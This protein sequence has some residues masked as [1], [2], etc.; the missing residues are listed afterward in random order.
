[1]LQHSANV[2]RN[3]QGVSKNMCST[4]ADVYTSYYLWAEHF[5]VDIEM[6]PTSHLILFHAGK[7]EWGTHMDHW[8]ISQRWE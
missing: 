1:M 7:Q 2:L 4:A 3:G 5:S 8:R 6:V